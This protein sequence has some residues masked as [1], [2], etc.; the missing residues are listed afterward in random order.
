[1]ITENFSVPSDITVHPWGFEHHRRKQCPSFIS[2]YFDNKA[3]ISALLQSA[4]VQC[5]QAT[6]KTKKQLSLTLFSFFACPQI[7]RSDLWPPVPGTCP[8]P[9]ATCA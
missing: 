4:S 9:P 5:K 7:H 8:A 3:S 6:I 1:M 2:K